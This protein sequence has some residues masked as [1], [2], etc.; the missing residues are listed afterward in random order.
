MEAIREFRDKYFFLSNF[1][2]SKIYYN[3]LTFKNAESAFQ[4]QKCCT[5][6]EKLQFVELSPTSAKRLGRRVNLRSD[7]EEVKEQ[8]MYEVVLAKFS[9]NPDIKEKLLDTDD[10]YL[11]EGNTWNDRFWGVCKGTGKNKLGHILMKVREELRTV[12]NNKNGCYVELVY[13]DIAVLNK[14]TAI[15]YVSEINTDDTDEYVDLAHSIVCEKLNLS[16]SEVV[17]LDY[18]LLGNDVDIIV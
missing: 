13:A 15:V 11:E 8:I 2:D 16:D 6:E 1:Y 10:M 4:A 7:W 17:I 5:K 14:R 3:G 18:R 12:E 9:Q